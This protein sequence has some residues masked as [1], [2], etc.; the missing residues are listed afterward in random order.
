MFHEDLKFISIKLA[1]KFDNYD[2]G[3][4]FLSQLRRFTNHLYAM[5]V[6]NK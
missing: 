1:C 3:K 6:V 2:I 4:L 5:K